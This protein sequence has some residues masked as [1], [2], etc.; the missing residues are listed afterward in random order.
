[1]V[2]NNA[3]IKVRR[4][5]DSA[6]SWFKVSVTT[7]TGRATREGV[8]VDTFYLANGPFYFIQTQKNVYSVV[9]ELLAVLGDS[10]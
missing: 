5:L 6:G 10:M 8:L 7:V 9:L 1:M 4:G 3:V 2:A